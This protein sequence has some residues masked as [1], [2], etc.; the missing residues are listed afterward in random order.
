[1]K[2]AR[3]L[4]FIGFSFVALHTSAQSVMLLYGSPC[5][6]SNM[7][8][9]LNGATCSSYSWSIQN[10]TLGVHY[11]VVGS[12]TQ[13]SYQITWIAPVSGAYAY[14]IYTCTTGSS[15]KWSPSY[16]VT[17]SITPAVSM[18]LN[19]TSLCQGST[20]TFSAT[21]TNGG[22]PGYSWHVDGAQVASGSSSTYVY[23]TTSL[24]P[25]SHTAYV[26]MSSDAP[27]ITAASATSATHSFTVTAKTTYTATVNGPTQIC[28]GTATGT[29]YITASGTPGNLSYQWY[30]NGS[31]ISLAT[32]NPLVNEPIA[33]GNTIYC[34]VNSDGCTVSPVQ[35]NTYTVVVTPSTTPSVGIYIPKL[36]YCTGETITFTSSQVASTY[37]WTLNGSQFSTANQSTLPVSTDGNAANTFSPGDVVRLDVSGLSGTCLTTTSA[38][39]TTSGTPIVINPVVTPTVNL[40]PIA[41]KCLPGG[42]TLTANATHTGP[43][44]TYTFFLDNGQV[45]SGSSNTFATGNLSAGAH[46]AYVVMYSNAQCITAATATSTVQSFTVTAKQNYTV[47]IS[48]PTICFGN[49]S[50]SFFAT[51]IG[52][53]QG[54]LTYKWFKNGGLIA[55]AT[56]NPMINQPIAYG[57]VIYCVVATSYWCS[58]T[59][60]QSNTFTAVINPVPTVSAANQTLCSG[61]TASIAISNPNGVSG[62]TFSW[63]AS[64][65]NVTGASAG[66]G[67]LISQ[68]L[69]ST[70]SAPGSAYYTITPTANGCTGN[71]IGVTV[72]VNPIPD[73]SISPSNQSICSSQSGPIAI[74]SPNAVSGTTFSWSVSASNVSGAS[75]GSGN[76]ISQILNNATSANG[77]AT[78]TITPTANGCT[79]TSVGATVTV[80]P[81]PTVS[82]ANQSICSNQTTSVAITNPNVVSGTTFDWT[83]SPS[84]VS[85]ASLGSG[86]SIAQ[87]LTNTTAAN[88]TATYTI[89]PTANGCVGTS[90]VATVTVKPIP[91]VSA[92]DQSICSGTTSSVAIT[93]PNAVSGT[94]FDWTVTTS[95][96]TGASAGSG[97]S[98]AQLLTNATSAN[99]TATYTVTPTANGCMG[100]SVNSIVTVKPIPTASAAGQT[101][102]SG[103]TTSIAIANPNAVSGTTFSWIVSA[104]NVSGAS[105]GSGNSIAQLL[106]NSTSAIGTASYTVTPMA[107]S[108]NGASVVATVTVNPIPAN[109]TLTPGARCGTGTV[110]LSGT[111]GANGTTL[112]WYDDASAG[113]LLATA[114]SYATPSITGTTS[115]W[116]SSYNATTTC[117]GTRVQVTATVN[118]TPANPTLTPGARCGTGTV[119]L[120]GTVGANGT[121]LR[122]YDAASA[123]TLLATAA[124]Y[125]T[126]SIAATTNYWASSYNATT[127]CEGAR[128]PITATIDA[129]PSIP[130]LAPGIRCG[131]GTVTLSGTTGANGTTLRWYNA[132]SAGTLLATATSYTTPSITGTTNYWA[133]SYN[134]TTM[135]EGTRVQVTATVNPIPTVA[136]PNQSICTGQTT[137]IA[138]TN[139]NAVAGTT[140]TWTATASGV[141]GASGGSGATIAQVLTS[142]AGGTVTYNIVPTANGCAGTSV[143]AVATVVNVTTAPTVTGNSRYGTGTLTLVGAGTP[144]SGSYKWYNSANTLLTTSLTYLT[145]SVS[146]SAANYMFARSVSSGGC[147][148]PQAAI[149]INVYAQPV[150]TAPQ[151]YVS[152]EVPLTLSATT[153]NTGYTWRNSANATVGTAQ[154]YN[155]TLPDTYT[156]TVTR[157]GATSLPASF[158]VYGPLYGV[159]MN[160][161]VSNN[162]LLPNITNATTLPNLAAEKVTQTI[163]YFDGLGRPLQN[164]ATQASPLKADIVTP[165]KYDPFGR[166]AKEYLPYVF[167][168]NGRYKSNDLTAQATFYNPATPYTNKIKTDAAPWAETVFESSPLNRVAQKGA[169]G[170][171]WQPNVATPANGKTIKME[172]LVNADGTLAG[173]EKIKIWT[174]SSVTLNTVQEFILS[175]TAHYPSNS[176]YVTVTKDEENRQVREYTDKL[177]KVIL[178]KVQEAPTTATAP[179]THVD[180]DWTLTYYIYDEFERLRFVLQPKFIFRNSIYDAYTA[181]QDKKNMLD[182][183]SFEYRYDQRGRMIYKRVPGAKQVDM[184]YD[185]WDRLVLSQDGNQKATTKWSFTKYDVLNRPII[186][187]EIGNTNTRDQMVTAVNAIANRNENAASGNGVGYT[188]N[189][190]YPTATTINDIYTITYYD[191]YTFKTNLVLGTAYNALIPAGFTGVVSTRV[192]N[193]VT[194][195]KIRVLE[196][197]PLQWLVTASYYDDRYRLLQSIGDG[198]LNNKNKITNEYYGLTPWI[199]KSLFNHGTALTSLTETTY[200][201]AG[202]A[203]EVWQ[204][205]D[206]LPATRT[207]IASHKYNELGELVEKN[208][209]AAASAGPFLQSN[210]YRYNIRGW[211]THINNSALSNDGTVNDDANDLFGMELKY[212]DAVPIN[213]VNTTAQFNGNISAIQWKT[214][215]LVDATAEKIYGFAYDP[216]NRLKD[217]TYATKNGTLWNANLN[218]LDENLTY[219]KNG[220]MRTLKRKSLYNSTNNVLVDD[221]VYKYKG[222]QLDA[223]LDNAGAYKAYGFA[224]TSILPAGEYGYDANGS[225]IDD[226]NKGLVAT[227]GGVL[228]NHLN[229]PREVRYYQPT[230]GQQKIVYTYSAAG[231]KL[232]KIAYN[233]AGTL[234]SR[235]DYVGGIQYEGTQPESGL[236]LATD[237]KFMMTAEGR[238]VKNAGTWQYEYFHKD[239]LG[240]SRVVYGHQKQVDEY[241]ATMETPLATKEQGQFYNLT[242]TRATA[243]NRTVPTIDVVLPDKSAETNGNL[244]GKA[245]GPAKMLQVAAGDRVQLEVF[246]R[247]PGVDVSS[248]SMITNLASAVTTTFQV[249]PGEAAYIALTNNVPPAASG[250]ARIA[251]LPKAYLFYILFTSSYVYQGQFGY[252]QVTTDA[253]AGHQKLSMDITIPTGGYL[254]TYVI[255]ESNVSA[256]TSVYFDDFTV[257]HTRTSPTLQVVQTTDYYPFGLAMAAQS[258]QKQS[259]LDNDYLYNGKELQD[260]HN[261]GW[262]DYGARMYDAALGRWWVV[263]PLTE[264]YPTLTPYNYVGNNPI[265]FVDPDG[266]EIN[267]TFVGG[268]AARKLFMQVMNNM[269]GGQFQM[270]LTANKGEDGKES[271]SFKV[272]LVDAEGLGKDSK[273]N[274]IKGD[275]NELSNGAKGFYRGLKE[276]VNSETVVDMNIAYGDPNTST[277]NYNSSTV[278][279]AD[280]AQWP[281]FDHSKIAQNGTTQGAKMLHEIR[282]QFTFRGSQRYRKGDGRN[283]VND[284]QAGVNF[285]NSVNGN[286]RTDR[287]S[288]AGRGQGVI[289]TFEHSNGTVVRY[290]VLGG[291]NSPTQKVIT[292]IPLPTKKKQ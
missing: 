191:D 158:I 72:I 126:I 165:I 47:S 17:G 24:A 208:I 88:G 229:L 26:I 15:S 220:N 85:G 51:V 234:I 107:N 23:S 61:L 284:H 132:A 118:P 214:N 161:V 273:G 290:Q 59:D 195:S 292:I 246:A 50:A 131:T 89:T 166:Q 216:L 86:N 283:V 213:G 8:F 9:Q 81:I 108:C 77:T 28:S 244:A 54:S 87:L 260:E 188:L 225:M 181:Q 171:V 14:C 33:G 64:T 281:E 177:G 268:E 111:V 204:T 34:I 22:T 274:A 252:A 209:H 40:S 287:G 168:N 79:G 68:I 146:A 215:N 245:I 13:A 228:Y 206:A 259:A 289:Q 95:N 159:N 221:L 232:R 66:S 172:Y 148:G 205:M 251:T 258:Y 110:G 143:N 162:V 184:V 78:Y 269:L 285:E 250:F 42:V 291:P 175:S 155:A 58:V 104:S 113:T 106:T 179:A 170:T 45:A 136:A 43:S 137:S 194:G 242:T 163:S 46:S 201:H 142:A 91:T 16:N 38:F 231:T 189:L 35:S 286:T 128:V 133:S 248:N 196:S 93:N 239:H 211:L 92:S 56:T 152:K 30:K 121:T 241:K 156:V 36:D 151:N 31:P 256:S 164:V 135:C 70:T 29:F 109:P 230:Y 67:N 210:D 102:C 69:N 176:L 247:Y 262:T 105:A 1:M 186:T 233:S 116:A 74:T 279:M 100:A 238:A 237:L 263:D 153:G 7:V 257:L 207:L 20:I 240:N 254:Y 154:T 218:L 150:I 261:L 48:T 10:A 266:R 255:N 173:Q 103:T 235:T 119:G 125:T 84:N 249:N 264:L 183:L 140:F 83:V 114:T 236:P 90:V 2:I 44:P 98:I 200:D 122:W 174:L 138:I 130:T 80:K 18:S 187:G 53:P 57:D 219:D 99:G 75:A 223:V 145:A 198:H 149:S 129:F 65:N 71:A 117:E 123:G 97:N 270:T 141:T 277:G 243:F 49:T 160:Y 19:T 275:E 199:T 101:F 21:P 253:R 27:C 185:P 6:G 52:E 280:V 73:V 124:S 55:G 144:A 169:P 226:Q 193:L 203:K 37:S 60:V 222:N 272:G 82:A 197:S 267:V 282:E 96:V 217:A 276:A 4:L 3:A 63:T 94:T 288:G 224:E 25:G 5:V 212:N 182:S 32:S 271:G 39:A 139:P 157:T 12:S 227:G 11:Q 190:T 180:N 202:R 192:K 134:A 278:D 115:Y 76:S 167:E 120:S 178:K 265:I 62:T 112:R 41:D 127:T 147:E